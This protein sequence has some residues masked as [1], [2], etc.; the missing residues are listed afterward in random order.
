MNTPYILTE[1]VGQKIEE[2]V[3]NSETQ[4]K[5]FE[6][7]W[8]NNNY[9]DDGFHYRFVSRS[10]GRVIDLAATADTF[11]PYRAIPKASRQI[12][13]ISNLLLANEPQ[14]VVY[15]ER[16]MQQQYQDPEQFKQAEKLAQDNAKQIGNW[17][18]WS[19][20][21]YELKKLL[22][23]M[24]MLAAKHSVSY[25]Q[26][27]PDPIKED[28]RFQVFDAFD[29]YIKSSC[30]SIYDS[31]YI[32]K[33]TP[34]TIEEL[35]A[36]EDFEEEQLAKITP[37]NKYASSEIKEAYMMSRY[38]MNRNTDKTATL[39]LKEGFLKEYLNEDN[40]AQVKKDLGNDFNIKDGDPVIRQVFSVAGLTLRDKYTSFP[41]YPFVDFRME[42][43]YIY[44]V[45]LIER[46]ISA[47]KSLDA[48]MSRIERYIGTQIVGVYM[49]RRGENYRINNIAGGAEI[50]YDTAPPAQMPLSPMPGFVFN[51]INQLESFIEEQ[52]ASTSSLG[53]LPPGVK[54][55]VAIESMKA[56]EYANLKIAS[57][58]LKDTVKRIAERM[59]ELA[60]KYFVNPKT[61]S[62]MKDNKP[63]YFDIIGERGMEAYK[64]LAQKKAIQVPNA[65][66]IKKDYHVDIDIQSGLGFTEEGKR[67]TMMQIIDYM[68]GLAVEQLI[69]PETLNI[70]LK[71][72]L[73]I[74][75]FG[76]TAEFMDSLD[77]SN[78][79]GK[80]DE[81]RILQMKTAVLEAMKEAGEVGP[82]ATEK[83]IQENKIGV[84]EALKDMG[85]TAPQEIPDNPELDAIPYKDA[86]EDIKRQM[87]QKAG[88]TPSK[89][90]SP[91]GTDQVVKTM[92]VLREPKEEKSAVQKRSST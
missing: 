16:V 13:G 20:E 1:Q 69:P 28:I 60:S 14:A 84:V 8:Y 45:P 47:N 65:T 7:R 22:T 81:Q 59:I 80:I 53:Q 62:Y 46:F 31:P 26:I 83:R 92:N 91:S 27:W 18:D 54:S 88:L 23:H 82:E 73:Q 89:T 42:P 49:K 56:T 67:A 19:W 70:V 86:P 52:G 43:G 68:R 30:Y 48:V 9:F 38:G 37:D 50:E 6:R 24:V 71:R 29:I 75:Q 40:K 72:F 77:A 11:I 74:F 25:L 90:V 4:R 55:G 57:D 2:L 36:N 3:K 58:Q 76:N 17:I 87:E 33:V 63:S 10:T 21:K 15:P 64:K 51:Y 32:I 41:E 61:I 5:P 66:V 85:V 78:M 35:K 34:T 39:L 12:R 44:Q 79:D